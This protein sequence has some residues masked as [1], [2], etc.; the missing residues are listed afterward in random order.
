MKPVTLSV[1]IAAAPSVVWNAITDFPGAAGRIPAI[2]SVEV[3]EGP[4]RGVGMRW[5]ETRTMFGRDATETMTIAEWRAPAR[6]GDECSYLATAVNHGCEYRSTL[7]V[8]PSGVGSRL[9]FEFDCRART[10]VAKMM[11]AVMMP[12]MGGA[13]RKAIQGD[14]DAIKIHCERVASSAPGVMA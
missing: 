5:R 7:R 13:M 6:P 8:A 2:K 3:L 11:S 4:E 1:E 10:L 9:S 12:L 14:L